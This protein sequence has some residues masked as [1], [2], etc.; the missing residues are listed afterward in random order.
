MVAALGGGH[1][2]VV[3][4]GHTPPRE[5]LPGFTWERFLGAEQMERHILEADAV[6]CHAGVG[7]IMTSVGLGKTPVALP[8]LSALGEHVD[9]HQ[10][11]IAGQFDA[12][13]FVVAC[14][15]GEDLGDAIARAQGPRA[16]I[17]NDGA[18]RRA[19]AEATR[20]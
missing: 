18:L 12:R 14:R 2:V 11:Q 3:Q 20:V 4:H 5:G 13:G 1:D 16:A 15:L 17:E 10:L 6:V 9:D 19:V 7:C 8:R